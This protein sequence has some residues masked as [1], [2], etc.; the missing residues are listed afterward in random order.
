M[1]KKITK[2]EKKDFIKKFIIRYYFDGN[3]EV[4]VSAKSKKQAEEKFY[5]GEFNDE[6]EYG[7]NYTV[8]SVEKF[9]Y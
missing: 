1:T 5:S 3:G 9:E 6:D 7:E 4:V 2:K 8:E